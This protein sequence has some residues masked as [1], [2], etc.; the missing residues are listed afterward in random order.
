MSLPSNST[1][2][3]EGGPLSV[4]GWMIGG[5][6][7]TIGA[8]YSKTLAKS[9]KNADVAGDEQRSGE[10]TAEADQAARQTGRE[11]HGGTPVGWGRY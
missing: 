2:A 5:C 11:G 8:M 4:P 1:M 10:E 7:Q 6:G 3:S 9:C